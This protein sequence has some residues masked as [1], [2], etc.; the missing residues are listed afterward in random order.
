MDFRPL[1]AGALL[2]A[3]GFSSPARAQPEEYPEEYDDAVFCDVILTGE[4]RPGA[5]AAREAARR[6]AWSY[7]DRGI[8]TEEEHDEALGDN[9]WAWAFGDLSEEKAE[10]AIA[11]CIGDY[12]YR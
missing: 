6:I 3:S 4:T 8:V 7:V 12:Q 11:R 2:L 10:E 1:V 5:E 9:R